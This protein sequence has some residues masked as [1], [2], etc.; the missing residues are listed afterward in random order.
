[1]ILRIMMLLKISIMQVHIYGVVISEIQ[2]LGAE[3]INYKGL[4]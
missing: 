4:P 1:M 2:L 3:P